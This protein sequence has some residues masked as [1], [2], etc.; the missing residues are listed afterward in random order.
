MAEIVDLKTLKPDELVIRIADKEIKVSNIP[1]EVAVDVIAK[2][3]ELQKEKDYSNREMMIV[4]RDIV[5]AVL[6]EAD[7]DI[8]GEWVR[9]NVNAFQMMRLIEKIVDPMLDAL[10]I[11]SSSGNTKG[12]K[13]K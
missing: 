11:R 1:F 13:K 12:T 8:D 6:H 3:D 7:G 5:V 2:F 10:G 9:K 4:F